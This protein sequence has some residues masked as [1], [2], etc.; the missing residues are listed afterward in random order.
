MLRL[1]IR[2]FLFAAW[3]KYMRGGNEHDELLVLR[4][5][6]IQKILRINSR[7]PWPVHFT[8]R[9]MCPERIDRGTRTPGLAVCCHIDGRNGIKMGKNVWIGPRVTIVSM[10]HNVNDYSQYTPERPVIIG[11]NCWLATNSIILPGVELA[12]HTIV[13]A[14]AVVTKSFLDGDV[15]IGGSPARILKRLG[16]YEG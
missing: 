3:P 7:V 12:P 16:K 8:S 9:I 10:N 5:W 13:A 4:H 15:V 1:L 6:A 2:K 11:D 14:G